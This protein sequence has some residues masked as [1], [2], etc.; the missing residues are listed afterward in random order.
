MALSVTSIAGLG[1]HWESDAKVSMRIF[2]DPIAKENISN[3]KI[4]L[5][6]DIRYFF[7]I[8]LANVASFNL[9]RLQEYSKQFSHTSSYINIECRTPSLF[10]FDATTDHAY[11]IVE[12]MDKDGVVKS[13]HR[14]D[15][16]KFIPKFPM[17]FP[18][19][20]FSRNF[21]DTCV[22]TPPHGA[23]DN[24]SKEP[25]KLLAEPVIIP[26]GLSDKLKDENAIIQKHFEYSRKSD[27]NK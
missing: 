12:N 6:R 19:P 26:N 23:A 25:S 21:E 13:T 7:D 24:I 10:A 1:Q 8:K 2:L 22:L 16:F 14:S 5:W 3:I 27:I 11:L 17:A 4:T 9:T 15:D 20:W 18:S